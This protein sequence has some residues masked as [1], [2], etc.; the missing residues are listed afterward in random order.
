MEWRTPPRG[1][2]SI[3]PAGGGTGRAREVGMSGVRGRR[4]AGAVGAGAVLLVS[5]AACST[6]GGEPPRGLGILGVVLVIVLGVG[7]MVVL[8]VGT[9]LV[10]WVIVAMIAELARL[11]LGDPR[12]PP[13]Q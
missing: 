12:P 7:A 13:S 6:N 10:G 3:H 9:L 2:P 11:V 1:R 8:M 5:V 4:A